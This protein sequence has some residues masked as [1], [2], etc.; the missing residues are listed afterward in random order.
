M[1]DGVKPTKWKGGGARDYGRGNET[2]KRKGVRGNDADANDAQHNG[3]DEH[4]GN[5][6]HLGAEDA[7]V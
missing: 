2:M 3:N 1:R 6:A 7:I 4:K 5:E